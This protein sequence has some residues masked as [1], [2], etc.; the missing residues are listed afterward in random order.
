MVPSYQIV[1]EPCCCRGIWSRCCHS[2]LNCSWQLSRHA[3]NSY[4][5]TS[6]MQVVCVCVWVWRGT[7]LVPTPMATVNWQMSS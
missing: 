5:S 7:L 2:Y 3:S 6:H 4:E 1:V